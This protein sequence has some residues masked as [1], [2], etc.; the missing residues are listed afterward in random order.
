MIV[1]LLVYWYFIGN[2][3]ILVHGKEYKMCNREV[4]LKVSVES[5]L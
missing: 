5:R 2:L 4:C 1:V 3:S